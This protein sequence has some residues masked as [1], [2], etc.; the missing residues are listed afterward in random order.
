MQVGR[1]Y[2]KLHSRPN[3]GSHQ[4]DDGSGCVRP[5]LGGSLSSLAFV[6]APLPDS[7]QARVVA[8]KFFPSKCALACE[9]PARLHPP[10]QSRTRFPLVSLLFRRNSRSSRSRSDGRAQPTRSC[11]K[12]APAQEPA[13]PGRA[14][15]PDPHGSTDPYLIL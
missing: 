7:F 5:L 1:R 6:H 2:R 8:R 4:P 3:E 14:A 12:S 15:P 11:C 13:G 9:P 10:P